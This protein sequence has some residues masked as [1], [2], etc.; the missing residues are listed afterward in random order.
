LLSALIDNV[1]RQ[2]KEPYEFDL[3]LRESEEDLSGIEDDLDDIELEL[4]A[5]GSY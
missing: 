4:R 1:V 2:A 5:L 3:L